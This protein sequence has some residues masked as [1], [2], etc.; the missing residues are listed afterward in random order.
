MNITKDQVIGGTPI[1]VVREMLR[2]ERDGWLPR[3][4][5]DEILGAQADSVLAALVEEGY[6][7]PPVERLETLSYEFTTQ[8][9]ALRMATAG[10]KLRRPTAQAALDALLNKIDELHG[11]PLVKARVERVELF[12]S[13]LD[14]TV[15]R[16]SD[17]DL[18][19]KVVRTGE[20][21]MQEAGDSYN[22]FMRNRLPEPGEKWWDFD[23][24]L[25]LRKIN[26]R[27][28]SIVDYDQHVRLLSRVPHRQVYP[29][30]YAESTLATP[31]GQESPVPP[32]PQ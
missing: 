12:G 3:Y 22:R 11:D 24:M 17:V 2:L 32:D 23:V 18:A 6:L 5:A 16:V 15:D 8:G 25:C 31:T 19:V 30:G 10:A 13:M 28:L 14:E 9:Y 21:T 27:V 20:M 4:L 29:R 26:R 7:E 1:L